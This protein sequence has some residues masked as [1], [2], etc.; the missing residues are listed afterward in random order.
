MTVDQTFCAGCLEVRSGSPRGWGEPANRLLLA[1]CKGTPHLLGM[2][3]PVTVVEVGIVRVGVAQ[4]LVP[5]P[6]RVRFAK[7]TVMAVLVMLVVNVTVFMLQ[8]FMA[9]LVPVAL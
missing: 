1:G 9:M 8:L 7:R 6:V 4:G 2:S 5:V 3:V